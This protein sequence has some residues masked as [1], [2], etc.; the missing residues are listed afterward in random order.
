MDSLR[1]PLTFAYLD[2]WKVRPVTIRF[3]KHE[4]YVL[5]FYF[6]CALPRLL[7]CITPFIVRAGDETLVKCSCNAKH[8][9]ALRAS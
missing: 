5:V 9:C 7:A 2:G 6:L 1:R 4:C 3:E 8:L